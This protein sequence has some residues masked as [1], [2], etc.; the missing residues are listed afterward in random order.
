MRRWL[1]IVLLVAVGVLAWL[2]LREDRVASKSVAGTIANSG[3]HPGAAAPASDLTAQ[4]GSDLRPEA[5]RPQREEQDRSARAVSERNEV[6]ATPQR[7]AQVL[8]RARG[9]SSQ[10][11][12]ADVW[13]EARSLVSPGEIEGTGTAEGIET[14]S[15]AMKSDEAGLCTFELVSGVD[16]CLRVLVPTKRHGMAE[17]SVTGLRPGERRELVLEIPDGPDVSLFGRLLTSDSAEPVAGARVSVI[18]AESTNRSEAEE[19]WDRETLSSTQTRGDGTFCALLEAWRFP[20]IRVEAAGFAPAVVTPMARDNDVNHPQL[21]RLSRSATLEA[22]VLAASGKGLSG[23]TVFIKVDGWPPCLP[24]A[25][26][27]ADL[28]LASRTELPPDVWSVDTGADGVA[29]FRDLPSGP[30]IKVEIRN[31]D[32]LLRKVPDWLRLVAGETLQVEYRI[33]AGTRVDGL[34]LDQDEHPVSKHT[35]WLQQSRSNSSTHF[36]S[37]SRREVIAVSESDEGGHFVLEDVP[38]GTWWIGPAPEGA[39]N[40]HIGE[41]ELAPY[42]QFL[43]LDGEPLRTLTLKVFRG[44][45]IRGRVLDPDGNA[46][47][48]CNVVARLGA[49]DVGLEA[50]TESDGSFSMGPLMPGPFTIVA[51]PSARFVRSDPSTA[52]GGDEGVILRVRLGGLVRGHVLGATPDDAST[53]SLLLIPLDAETRALN[54]MQIDTCK[55]DGSFLFERLLPGPFALLARTPDGRFAI[56]P[57]ITVTGGSDSG[58]LS[59]PLKPGAKLKLKYTGESTYAELSVWSRGVPL[60]FMAGLEQGSE[61]ELDLPDGATVLEVK[62]EAGRVVRKSLELKSGETTSLELS[63]KD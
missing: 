63:D 7:M 42:A 52:R 51:Q 26:T 55:P 23:A 18:V 21:I 3:D 34:L 39:P 38:P 1:P 54:L 45:Y 19:K 37:W 9:K 10:G 41:P 28:I 59:L 17:S 6:E 60:G 15:R 22:H 49:E 43:M 8:V 30:A 24:D 47:S 58:D 20:H 11:P 13:I 32:R 5:L 40:V 33:G 4:P 44:L 25:P 61:Q 14:D 29:I 48:D 57:E 31:G 50:R 56:Q 2:M 62:N 36:E 16:W 35:I 12:L 53:V 46:L 27:D